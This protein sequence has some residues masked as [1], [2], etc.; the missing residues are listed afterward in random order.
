MASPPAPSDQPRPATLLL[1]Q[2]AAALSDPRLS[3]RAA[4]CACMRS[5]SRSTK[6]LRCG[7]G[8]WASRVLAPLPLRLW[9]RSAYVLLMTFLAVMMPFFNDVS[10][11]EWLYCRSGS[12]APVVLVGCLER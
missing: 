7:G 4:A 9:W 3:T 6:L 10:G 5:L 8:A 11:V 12:S 1:P 2:I